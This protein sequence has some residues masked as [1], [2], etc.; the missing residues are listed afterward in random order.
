MD[1]ATFALSPAFSLAIL[2]VTR[3]DYVKGLASSEMSLEYPIMSSILVT[4]ILL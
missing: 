1:R 2:H 3:I 4:V